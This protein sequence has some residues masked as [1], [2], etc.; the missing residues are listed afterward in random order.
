MDASSGGLA[1]DKTK[2]FEAETPGKA[3]AA[4]SEWLSDF[5]QHGPL[6]IRAIRV[7]ADQDAFVAVLTYS[8]TGRR[9]R[10][11]PVN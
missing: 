9:L 8:D 5:R 2:I 7:E 6:N 1:P 10:L 11:S 4:A 3:R